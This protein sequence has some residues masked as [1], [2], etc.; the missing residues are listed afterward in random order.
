MPSTR[1]YSSMLMPTL[2]SALRAVGSHGFHI[3]RFKIFAQN[4]AEDV[5]MGDFAVQLDV[6]RHGEAGQQ[7]ELLMHHAD[8]FHHGVMR[9][10]YVGCLAIQQHLA[11]KAAVV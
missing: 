2:S 7:H 6:F 8:A 3:Q 4:A 5:G 1:V 9:R 10:G 11:L